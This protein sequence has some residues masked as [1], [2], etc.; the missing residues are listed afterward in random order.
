MRLPTVEEDAARD[1][2]ATERGFALSA[3]MGGMGMLVTWASGDMPVAPMAEETREEDV[4]ILRIVLEDDSPSFIVSGAVMA[5]KGSRNWELES[6]SPLLFAP[7][8]TSLIVAELKTTLYS[9]SIGT[10][11]LSYFPW[12]S[13]QQ[14]PCA[15]IEKRADT[16]LH[17]SER[18]STESSVI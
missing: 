2:E 5:L 6:S 9:D 8:S 3:G 18:A 7:D 16:V 17:K 13:K 12:N 4:G 11:R 14:F 1:L 10:C 15:G